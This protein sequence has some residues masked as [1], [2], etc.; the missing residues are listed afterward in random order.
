MDD[1]TANINALQ[2]IISNFKKAPNRAYRKKT[3][4][5]KIEEAKELKNSIQIR[6]QSIEDCLDLNTVELLNRKATS[7]TSN[8]ILLAQEKITELGNKTD[9]TIKNIAICSLFISRLK[10][11]VTQT[12]MANLIDIIKTIST[13]VPQF[14]GTVD[15]LKS[16]IDALNLAKTLETAENKPTI[17]NVILTKLEGKARNAFPETP[18]SINVIID[19]LKNHIKM[20]PPEQILAKMTNMKQNTTLEAFCLEIENLVAK[21]EASY[22]SK[23]VPPQVAKSMATKEGIKSLTTGIKDEKTSLIIR[24]GSFTSFSDAMTKALEESTTNQNT[25]IFFTRT[26]NGGQNRPQFSETTRYDNGYFQGR[27]QN[28]WNNQPPQQGWRYN[29]QSRPNFQQN[30]RNNYPNS[31]NSR[32][33]QQNYRNNPSNSQQSWRGQNNY[34]RPGGNDFRNNRRVYISE[35]EQR[36]STPPQVDAESENGEVIQPRM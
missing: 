26:N 11:K 23:E 29:Q 2:K 22:I 5:K 20:A 9:P 31:Q 25:S 4:K 13:I 21:L 3:L 12:K 34:N 30:W 14:D 17:I 32:N 18:M 35:N 6:L 28:R 1:I 33:N 19:T 36:P 24:A 27:Y 7:L 15:K 10:N 16:F 8:I